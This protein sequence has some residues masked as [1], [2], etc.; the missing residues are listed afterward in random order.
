METLETAISN[1]KSVRERVALINAARFHSHSLDSISK[2]NQLLDL[3]AILNQFSTLVTSTHQIELFK[4]V[5]ILS[6]F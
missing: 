3:W 4:C 1:Q 5:C 6:Q 2:E